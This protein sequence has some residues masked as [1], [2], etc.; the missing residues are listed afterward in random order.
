MEMGK[1]TFNSDMLG[2]V[3][4]DMAKIRS[5]QTDDKVELHLTDGTVIKTP[6]DQDQPGKV[7]SKATENIKEHTF[8]EHAT[9]Y[10]FW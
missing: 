10:S 5:F 1:M 9:S 7:A 3:T 2:E 6:V 4:I 8:S